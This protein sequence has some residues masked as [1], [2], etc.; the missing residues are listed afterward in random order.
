MP[1]RASRSDLESAVASAWRTTAEQMPGV[2]LV[3]DRCAEQPPTP[4]MERAMNRA[5]EHEWMR[6]AMVAG[7]ASALG[8]VRPGGGSARRG[9]RPEMLGLDPTPVPQSQET[10]VEAVVTVETTEPT[11]GPSFV[12]RIRAVLAA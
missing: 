3:I 11:A 10:A 8:P 5:R 12:D 4:E 6:L 2:R 1:W 7:L 9:P